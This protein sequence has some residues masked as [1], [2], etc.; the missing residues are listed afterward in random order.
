MDYGDQ[1][2]E[3]NSWQ[4]L[5]TFL[6]ERVDR[7]LHRE[8]SFAQLSRVNDIYRSSFSFPLLSYLLL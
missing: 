1:S 3:M 7:S 8:V 5:Q 6:W 2:D 4:N